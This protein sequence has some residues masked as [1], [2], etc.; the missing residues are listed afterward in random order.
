MTTY[1][2]IAPADIEI[3]VEMMRDFYAID[4]YPI[5]AEAS[6]SLFSEFLC[7]S[8]LGRAWIIETSEKI[9]GYVILTFVFSF[10]FGGRIAFVD[11]LF[12]KKEY[13]GKGIGKEAIDF[14][15]S[16]AQKLDLKL[17]YLEVEP[18]NENAKKLYLGKGFSR[19][20]RELMIYRNE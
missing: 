11:E 3:V 17:L 7:N 2:P 15:K 18:H 13:R 20:S 6:K 16:E 1:R 10:E 9:A 8:H 5:N 19:H 4:G 12:I 14:V